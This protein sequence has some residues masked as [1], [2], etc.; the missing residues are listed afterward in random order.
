M[1]NAVAEPGTYEQVRE[2]LASLRPQERD[3]VTAYTDPS[4][5]TYGNKTRSTEAGYPNVSPTSARGFAPQV[6]SR[7]RVINAVQT[8]LESYEAGSEVRLRRE[9]DIALGRITNTT[10]TEQYDSDGKLTGKQVTTAPVPAAVQAKVLKQ[11]RD[12]S[13]ETAVATAHNKL[14]SAELL[15]LGKSM[16][17]QAQRVES[18]RV[19]ARDDGPVEAQ[20]EA[21]T[22]SDVESHH[23]A[24]SDATTAQE[25]V[26][27]A[28]ERE[29]STD[30]GDA[31]QGAGSGTGTGEGGNGRVR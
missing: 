5:P 3:V 27:V 13:G 29:S 4:S 18:A 10:V 23:P 16:L 28:T 9:A 20:G 15:K 11:I 12:Y 26:L 1:S 21:Q 24:P 17:H 19:V 6:F 30:T 14:L 31:A 8:I 7:Q 22:G 25:T 2:A